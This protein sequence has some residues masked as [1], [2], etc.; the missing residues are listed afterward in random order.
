MGFSRQGYW[1]GLPFPSLGDLPDPRIEPRSPVLQ[2]DSLPTELREEL[3][4]RMGVGGDMSLPQP[5]KAPRGTS[6]LQFLPLHLSLVFLSTTNWHL[7]STYL[8]GGYGFSSGDVW[9]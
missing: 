3:K 7:P 1:S 8:F 5:R 4:Q 2:A 9:M 6:W